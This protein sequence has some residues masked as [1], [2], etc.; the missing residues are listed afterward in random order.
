MSQQPKGWKE[1]SLAGVC[2]RP[3]TDYRTGDWRSFRPVR[4]PKKCTKCLLCHMVCP[5][6]SIKWNKETQDIE[7]DYDFCKGCGICANE[8]PVKA[9]VMV[10][11]GG[12]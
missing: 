9:I 3:A 11:E 10:Q 12:E 6:A 1:L 7:F 2:W 5:D 8:C 4:D